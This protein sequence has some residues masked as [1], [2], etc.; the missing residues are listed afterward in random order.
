MSIEEI[1]FKSIGKKSADRIL[2]IEPIW[3]KDKSRYPQ[4]RYLK[5]CRKSLL[6]FYWKTFLDNNR[7]GP[8]LG[9]KNMRVKK[10]IK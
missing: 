8:L 1:S 10:L 2:N 9:S 4:K 7:F 5:R 6:V 3:K